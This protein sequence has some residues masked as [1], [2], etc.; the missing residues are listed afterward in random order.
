MQEAERVGCRVIIKTPVATVIRIV[1][2]RNVGPDLG[3]MTERIAENVARYLA[4]NQARAMMQAA[5]AQ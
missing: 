3:L 4:L 1:R 2:V 5:A